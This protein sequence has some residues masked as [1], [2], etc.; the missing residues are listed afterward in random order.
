MG[1]KSDNKKV[2]VD[3]DYEETLN[4]QPVTILVRLHHIEEYGQTISYSLDGET[5]YSLPSGFFAE[6]VDFLRQ[7]KYISDKSTQL[8]KTMATP[9]PAV[10]TRKSPKKSDKLPIPNL[11]SKSEKPEEVVT[12][13]ESVMPD[14]SSS[15]SLQSLEAIPVQPVES[16]E[17]T[18]VVS[19]E[20][21]TEVEETEEVVTKTAKKLSDEDNLA[22]L[23]ERLDAAKRAEKT[24][25]TKKLKKAHKFEE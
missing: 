22:L 2:S 3:F 17:E 9:G 1:I 18:D 25:Q 21:E 24:I 15:E 11:S 12:E 5:Y 8:P 20:Q 6:V 19:E 14:F 10:L 4:G 13:N 16:V 7:Q 23:Q